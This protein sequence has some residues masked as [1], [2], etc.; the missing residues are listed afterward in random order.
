[1]KLCFIV[2]STGISGGTKVIF[3]ISK[4]FASKGHEVLIVCLGSKRHKWFDF[5]KENVKL[6]YIESN[7]YIPF[8]GYVSMY[9]LIDNVN[10]ILKIPYKPSRIRYLAERIPSG[11]DIYV[12]TYF[13]SAVSLYLSA[14]DGKKIYFVQD[15]PALVLE[16]EG[17]YGLKLFNLT[18]QLPFDAFICNSRY[19]KEIVTRLNDKALTFVG[20]MG[21]DT[22]L[23]KPGDHGYRK[24]RN[25]FYIMT[26]LHKQKCKGSEIAIRALNLLAKKLP[27]HAILVGRP[28]FQIKMEFPFTLY[29]NVPLRQIPKLY[30]LSDSFIFTSYVESFGLP[31]LEAMACGCPV[32]TTNCRGNMDY[33]INYYNSIVV[34][35][36]DPNAV[37]ESAYQVLRDNSLRRKLIEGGLKTA[38]EWSWNKRFPALES[39]LVNLR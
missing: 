3:E 26:I 33:A 32:I 9:G 5:G 37:A 16:N 1:M 35:P 29:E 6:L 22:R 34:P 17:Y 11:Y 8:K 14:L 27:I 10:K 4:L 24:R 25:K 36:G 28:S 39:F 21:I 38:N 18:L 2:W 20:G 31:P 15:T 12:A 30:Q 13:P 19:T 23:F 7:I